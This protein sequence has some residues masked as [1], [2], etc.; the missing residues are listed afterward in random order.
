MLPDATRGFHEVHF[1]RLWTGKEFPLAHVLA[2]LGFIIVW[3]IE[4][5]G[6][7]AGN[8]H[9][10]ERILAVTAQAEKMGGCN[11]CYVQ[12]CA[13]VVNSLL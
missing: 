9:V 6:Q 3:F 11:I 13:V 5:R 1:D 4:K 8:I 7:I 12:V 2:A 10:H